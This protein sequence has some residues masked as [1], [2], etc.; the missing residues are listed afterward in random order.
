M[1]R[2]GDAGSD[3]VEVIRRVHRRRRDLAASAAAKAAWS[4]NIHNG[5]TARLGPGR[6]RANCGGKSAA[7]ARRVAPVSRMEAA[8]EVLPRRPGTSG[9]AEPGDEV[10]SLTAAPAAA[11]G[12]CTAATAAAAGT[13]E[14]ADITAAATAAAAGTAAATAAA[15][16]C[17]LGQD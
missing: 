5:P 4:R 2:L 9:P 12:T 11:T 16:A 10:R 13:D 7:H 17:G 3:D 1:P 8:R 6:D 14:A 15:A